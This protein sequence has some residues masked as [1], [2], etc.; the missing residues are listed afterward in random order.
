MTKILLRPGHIIR[1][2]DSIEAEEKDGYVTLRQTT[3]ECEGVSVAVQNDSPACA[4]GE[5]LKNRFFAVVHAG[6]TMEAE[7][8][9]RKTDYG[10]FLVVACETDKDGRPKKDGLK[11]RFYQTGMADAVPY[12]C[13]VGFSRDIRDNAF[14]MSK[15]LTK[16]QG[17]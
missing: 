16:R 7:A 3:R 6:F 9:K 8:A 11:A 10:V 4:T 13:V 17:F 1:I 14:K 12:P 2:D 5:R 15:S